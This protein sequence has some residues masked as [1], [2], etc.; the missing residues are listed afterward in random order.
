MKVIFL[1]IDGVLQPYKAENRFGKDR[2]ALREQLSKEKGIDYSIYNEYDV[3]ACAL[4]W[5]KKA[6]ERL[7][8][9]ITETGAKIV[10][11]SDW[12]SERLPY[13]VRDL[14][15]I[16]DMGKY[17]YADTVDYD[18]EKMKNTIEYI[19]TKNP[20]KK[21]IGYRNVEIL[22]FV[23]NHKDITNFVAIDDMDLS[24]GLEN[25]FVHTYNVIN[26]EQTEKCIEILTIGE[27]MI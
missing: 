15:S 1:D 23:F 21:Y 17:W 11:S 8:K 18:E 7:L 22:D 5:D 4:D 27:F 20:E 16:W 13:K 12:R 24:I 3:A 19:K 26:D 2:I 10:V 6:V 9:I 25:N 14:L